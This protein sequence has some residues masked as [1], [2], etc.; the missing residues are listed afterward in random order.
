MKAEVSLE[1]TRVL[2][3]RT[4]AANRPGLP[5]SDGHAARIYL[6]RPFRDSVSSIPGIVAVPERREE[7]EGIFLETGRGRLSRE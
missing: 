1:G 3:P 5:P 7:A 4:P 6:R 2:Y